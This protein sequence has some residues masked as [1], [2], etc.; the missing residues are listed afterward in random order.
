VTRPQT[1]PTPAT[2]AANTTTA[3]RQP[4]PFDFA[5]ANNL[6]QD[7]VDRYKAGIDDP[8]ALRQSRGGDGEF[9]TRD[10]AHGF[11]TKDADKGFLVTGEKQLPNLRAV[12]DV[13]NYLV[14][15][16]AIKR[17]SKLEAGRK[18]LYYNAP[19]LSVRPIQDLSPEILAEQDQAVSQI[20]SGYGGSD[21]A[22]QAIAQN[23][24]NSQRLQARNQFISQR[25]ANLAQERARWDEQMRANQQLSADTAAKNLDREQDFL[26]YD[27]GRKVAEQEALKDLNTRTLSAI[28][29]VMDAKSQ[30]EM[31]RKAYNADNVRKHFEDQIRLAYLEPDY[32][33]QQDAI[34]RAYAWYAKASKDPATYSTAG[35]P[36]YNEANRSALEGTWLGNLI[37]RSNR[38]I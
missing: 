28:G 35:I 7:V 11:S 20:R 27:L 26:D 2:T 1:A 8:G 23:M 6:K 22:S 9:L 33:R 17:I 37:T 16:A 19:S 4:I 32:G 10:A 3:T 13:L 34:R 30:F 15:R 36:T 31:T 29:P 12:P 25:A 21:F 24:A 38:A 5:A 14:G 18:R